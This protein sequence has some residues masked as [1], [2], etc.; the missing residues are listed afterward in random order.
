[1]KHVKPAVRNG[2][3]AIDVKDHALWAQRAETR[4]A[5]AELAEDRIEALYE[6]ARE[7]FWAD[8]GDLASEAGFDWHQDGRSGGWLVISGTTFLEYLDAGNPWA[9][10]GGIDTDDEDGYADTYVTAALRER[11][12]FL[13]FA[14]EIDNAMD[15][16]G[17]IFLGLLAEE[18]ADLHARRESCLVR[19]EN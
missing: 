11:D 4:E 8:A 5:Y 6:Q 10:D 15:Q 3:P 7:Q 13:A 17:D 9:D 14:A 2:H 1:M 16:A 18:V 12:R 19:G